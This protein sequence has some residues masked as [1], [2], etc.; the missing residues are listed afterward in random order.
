MNEN[1][2]FELL[3][4]LTIVSFLLQLQNQSKLFGL[5]DVQADN[6]RIAEDIHKHLTEQDK[7]INEIM[8][9]LKNEN[10]RENK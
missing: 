2:Q 9:I 3:D 6:N 10:H 8:E 7:K 5:A 1:Q 4:V